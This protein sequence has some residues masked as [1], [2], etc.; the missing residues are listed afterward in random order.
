MSFRHYNTPEELS[1]DQWQSV[2]R[3]SKI[4]RLDDVRQK[5]A[6][7]LKDIFFAGDLV[8]ALMCAKE[9]NLED[10]IEPLSNKIVSQKRALS[11]VE[12]EKVGTKIAMKIAH[13]H[14]AAGSPMPESK[15]NEPDD[16]GLLVK[17][18]PKKK[19]GKQ[20]P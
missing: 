8:E 3:L 10:W 17:K 2:L 9:N 20:F 7:N 16:W 6:R 12:L 19:G 13:A 14:G 18:K 4:F 5:A 1:S 15:F 11:D